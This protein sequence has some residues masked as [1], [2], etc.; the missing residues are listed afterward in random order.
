MTLHLYMHYKCSECEIEYLPYN[1]TIACPKCGDKP[2][3]EDYFP[4]VEGICESF[5][6]NIEDIGN[7]VPHCWA[8]IDISD[9][10]QLFFFK[11]FSDWIEK[12]KE[13]EPQERAKAFE[14]F[15]NNIMSK[16]NFKGREYLSDYVTDLAITIY[17][18]FFNV[19]G[20][21]LEQTDK[22]LKVIDA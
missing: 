9:N 14:T 8:S 13:H 17:N 2:Q 5:L 7:I 21:L 11:V 6:F 10:L 3:M 22:G 19:R 12:M 20:I 15:L 18:E 1:D 4:F 16:I